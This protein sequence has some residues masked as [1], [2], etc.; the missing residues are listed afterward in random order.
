M[1][2]ECQEANTH[3]KMDTAVEIESFQENSLNVQ[4]F[5]KM[6]SIQ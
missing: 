4:L 3:H 1:K 5:S 2:C 6:V